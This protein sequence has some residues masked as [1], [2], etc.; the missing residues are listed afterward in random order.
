MKFIFFFYL[1]SIAATWLSV[2]CQRELRDIYRR[3]LYS[4]CNK[5]QLAIILWISFW[6]PLVV[7][8]YVA[9]KIQDLVEGVRSLPWNTGR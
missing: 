8:D 3:E 4:S 1:F 6:S 5:S 2:Y 7:L 9:S